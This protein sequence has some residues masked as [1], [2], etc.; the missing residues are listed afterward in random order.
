MAVDLEALQAMLEQAVPYIRRLNLKIKSLGD[1]KVTS[2]MAFSENVSNHVAT[3]HAGAIFT[4]GETTGAALVSS[5][6]DMGKLVIVVRGA[7]VNY[8][9]PF[10]E[11]LVCTGTI[12]P[13]AV[14]T[15]M[16][17]VERDGKYNFPVKLQ[18]TNEKGELAAELEFE[19]HLRKIN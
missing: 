15:A 14:E 12:E 2:E 18:M 11:R 10:R 13:L 1:G 17:A 16:A 3:V 6:L 8:R 4:A 9:K 19:Y 7:K 5:V